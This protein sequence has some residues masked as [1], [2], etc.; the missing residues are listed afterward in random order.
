MTEQP[1]YYGENEHTIYVDVIKCFSLY[2][3]FIFFM[4][5]YGSSPQPFPIK[6]GKRRN[7]G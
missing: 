5:F 3:V 7:K 6:S 2:F 1:F 4:L